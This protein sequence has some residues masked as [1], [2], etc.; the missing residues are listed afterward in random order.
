MFFR[1]I[2]KDGMLYAAL[3]APLLAGCAFH[4]GVPIIE[5]AL[6]EYYLKSEILFGYYLLF[7]LFLVIMTPFIICFASSLVILTEYD[8]NM[9]SYMAVTPVGKRGYIISRLVFPALISVFAS[10]MIMRFFS[11]TAWPLM[12]LFVTCIFSSLLSVAVSLFLVSFSHNRVEGMAM[13]KLSGIILLGLPVPFFLL[14]D[15]QYLFS[16]LP[17]FWIAKLC[18]EGNYFYCIPALLTSFLWMWVLYGRFVK[19][20]HAVMFF[21]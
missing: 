19:N 14:S 1:Q 13:S 2:S 7:D 4:F 15:V 12:M 11:L 8:E 10:A 5:A 17:S 6:C 18:L 16:F 21:Y 3:V 20:F 9:T